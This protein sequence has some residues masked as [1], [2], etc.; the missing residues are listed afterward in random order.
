M[1][2]GLVLKSSVVLKNSSVK[3]TKLSSIKDG[4]WQKKGKNEIMLVETKQE[5]SSHNIA[6]LSNADI[7]LI[8]EF[9]KE[10]IE[11]NWFIK[12]KA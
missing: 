7:A 3:F 10:G 5:E 9:V 6:V 2:T 1:L 4:W 8:R 12:C 11:T